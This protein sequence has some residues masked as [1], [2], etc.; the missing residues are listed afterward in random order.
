MKAALRL[1][2]TFSCVHWELIDMTI[3]GAPCAFC[4][5][6]KRSGVSCAI[7]RSVP[8]PAS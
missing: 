7:V 1:V 2:L 6:L 5:S 4:D 8:I 3:L